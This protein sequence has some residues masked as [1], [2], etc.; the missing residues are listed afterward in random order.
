[1]RGR[2]KLITLVPATLLAAFLAAD[3]V[4]VCGDPAFTMPVAAGFDIAPYAE[5]SDP[6]F[7]SFDADG[8]LYTGRDASGSGGGPADAVKIHRIAPGG[9]PVTAVK[10]GPP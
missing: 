7:L 9:S 10:V 2:T 6:I 5:V 8:N 3:A 1:M 4:A